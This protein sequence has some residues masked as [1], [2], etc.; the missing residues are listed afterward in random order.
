MAAYLPPIKKRGFI[1]KIKIE[2]GIIYVNSDYNKA[3]I[4][5]A[6]MIQGKWCSPY[7]TFPE[8]NREEVRDLLLET[9]GEAD[10]LD[11]N[12]MQRVTVEIDLDVYKDTIGES[13]EL[14]LDNILV[15]S[16]MSRDS[17]VKLADNVMLVTGGFESSGGSRQHPCVNPQKGTVLKVKNIP[18]RLY[19]KIK[20]MDGVRL[21]S[22]IDKDALVKEKEKLLARL[23]EIENLLST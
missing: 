13:N 12:E 6:R 10:I 11:D 3:F 17:Y 23:E 15:A 19:E 20:E 7:W 5:G 14:R 18:L 4:S 1:M 2:N 21:V 8:E 9:Y 16:R 22:E